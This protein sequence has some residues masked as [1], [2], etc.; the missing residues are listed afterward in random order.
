MNTRQER[1]CLGLAEGLPQSRA[2]I[3][4]GYAARGNAAEASASQLLRN[5]KVAARI[6][7]LQAA[8]ARRSQITVDDLVAELEDMRKLAIT[9]KNPAAGVAA[10]MGKAKLLGLIVDRA[11]VA[12]TMRKP[13]RE[14]NE[15]E[16]MSL[17][18]W[19]AKFAPK[20]KLQ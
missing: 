9:T 14:P 3:E 10:V 11:E 12:T 2:Y 5:P 1:F 17:D 8:A 13:L 20:A 18:D 6:A 7:E 4:A 19:T 16:R 15:A